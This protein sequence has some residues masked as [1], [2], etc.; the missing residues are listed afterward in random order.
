MYSQTGINIVCRC[1]HCSKQYDLR[2]VLNNSRK[3]KTR[4]LRCPSKKCGKIVGHA[5]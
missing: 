3:K 1:K 2:V 4:I 5:Q